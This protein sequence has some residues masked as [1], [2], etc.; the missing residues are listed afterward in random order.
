MKKNTLSA[1]GILSLG[2]A[3]FSMH[4]GASSMIWPMSWGKESGSLVIPAFLGVYLTGVFIPLL[5]YIALA[6]GEGTFYELSQRI[7]PK[8]AKFFCNLTILVLGPFFVI[9]RM[10]AAAWDA[11]LQVT[12]YKS[13]NMIPLLL[14]TIIYYL[15]VYWFISEKENTIDKISKILLPVLLTTV[16]GVIIKG[17]LKPLS[18]QGPKMYND[19]AFIYGFLEGYATMELPCA[20]IFGGMIINRLK[21]KNID[22]RRLGKY[23]IFVGLIGTGILAVSHFFHM[24]IGSTTYGMF[25]GLRYSALY[26]EVVVQLWGNLGGIIFNIGLLFSAL[27]CAVGL[28]SSTSEFYEE[29]SEGKIRYS[30]AAVIILMLSG[31]V[32]VLGL[33]N[34][35]ILAEPILTIIYPPAIVMTIYYALIPNLIYSKKLI[36][37]MRAAV[38]TA[39][40]FG[41]IDGLLGYLYMFDISIGYF[42]KVYRALPLSNYE[43][44]W[45]IFSVIGGIIGYLNSNREKTSNSSP[46]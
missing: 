17:I 44:S 29:V 15:V 36:S 34:I 8:F 45:I 2:G 30:N 26:A 19:P 40:L 9:P 28:T 23:L 38:I 24:Y 5:G 14:F 22:G 39:L 12:D 18:I 13:P 7:S 42:E 4:F 37:S 32:S 33:G 46:Q 41:I 16:A 31:T 3:L 20:L 1:L 27:T 6:N 11:F 10:S 21:F 35:V 25:E 43:L